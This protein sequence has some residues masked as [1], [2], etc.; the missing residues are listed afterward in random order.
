MIGIDEQKLFNFLDD[1]RNSQEFKERFEYTHIQSETLVS[2][3]AFIHYK[4]VN[5][6]AQCYESFFPNSVHYDYNEHEIILNYSHNFNIT[7]QLYV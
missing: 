1:I 7:V 3:Y 2:V 6:Y 4:M 5:H